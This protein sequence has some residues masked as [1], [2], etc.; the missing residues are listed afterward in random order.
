M[1]YPTST[2]PRDLTVKLFYPWPDKSVEE[3][4][5]PKRAGPISLVLEQQYWEC[6][7]PV[8]E[9]SAEYNHST[10]SS[11]STSSL[12]SLGNTVELIPD[13]FQEVG[14]T[15]ARRFHR[16]HET[17]LAFIAVTDYATYLN[18]RGVGLDPMVCRTWQV[19]CR[20][21]SGR[22]R[23][24][25]DRPRLALVAGILVQTLNRCIPGNV[26][27]WAPTIIEDA[28]LG[29]WVGV[30]WVAA[31]GTDKMAIIVCGDGTPDR[32]TARWGAH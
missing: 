20:G 29:Q 22:P 4:V 5:S 6:S 31:A 1:C 27:G 28:T 12:A 25:V 8:R 24:W 26:A 14:M 32:L 15:K 7:K 2:D 13:V 19:E 18:C 21:L 17:V 9:F 11:F 3:Y 10:L 16:L 23:G 30:Q